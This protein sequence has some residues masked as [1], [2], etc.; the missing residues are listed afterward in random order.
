M[1]S[2]KHV[3]QEVLKQVSEK[4]SLGV[5]V[6]PTLMDDSRS[7]SPE[8]VGGGGW[9]LACA[10]GL[11][12]EGPKAKPGHVPRAAVWP[13]LVPQ[14]DDHSALGSP[15]SSLP[16]QQEGKNSGSQVKIPESHTQA[17]G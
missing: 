12:W 9:I 6:V 2:V 1:A 11:R 10:K 7:T 15:E 17:K 16:L 8:E 3:F 5:A 4:A 14:G 13:P